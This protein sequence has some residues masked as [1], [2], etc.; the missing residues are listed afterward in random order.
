MTQHTDEQGNITQHLSD[1]LAVTYLKTDTVCTIICGNNPA[2]F[3]R[4]VAVVE[5]EYGVLCGVEVSKNGFGDDLAVF[6]PILPS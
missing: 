6:R 4:L 2:L 1:D 5:E 3:K